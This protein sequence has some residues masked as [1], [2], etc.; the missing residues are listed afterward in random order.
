M[1]V[2]AV[3]GRVPFTAPHIGVLVCLSVVLYV[4]AQCTVT[5]GIGGG[6]G[7]L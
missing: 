4:V 2:S 1:P 5:T 3:D 7:E 6:G